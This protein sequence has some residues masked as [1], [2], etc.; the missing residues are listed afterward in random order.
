MTHRTPGIR[1]LLTASRRYPERLA[2]PGAI[3]LRTTPSYVEYVYWV[4]GR[5][6]FVFAAITADRAER[7][8]AFELCVNTLWHLNAACYDNTGI[9]A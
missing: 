7:K 6:V 5:D 2:L 4:E 3:V 8:A 9:S 1:Q